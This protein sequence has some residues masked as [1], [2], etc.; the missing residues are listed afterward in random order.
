MSELMVK[1]MKKRMRFP[2]IHRF[3]F[4]GLT[5]A[6]TEGSPGDLFFRKVLKRRP[7][8]THLG[9]V[10]AK[11]IAPEYKTKGRGNV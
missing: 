3:Q 9:D 10:F 7:T 11:W 2:V 1:L 6:V 8:V 4:C 5:V